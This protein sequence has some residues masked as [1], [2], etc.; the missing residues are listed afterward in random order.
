[1]RE[2]SHFARVIDAEWWFG[3]SAGGGGGGGGR[4]RRGRVGE[5]LDVGGGWEGRA[6]VV[7]GIIDGQV[8]D[9][10]GAELSKQALWGMGRGVE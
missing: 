7:V 4:R 2:G 3:G 8:P 1:M 9:G 10:D 6:A 5:Y